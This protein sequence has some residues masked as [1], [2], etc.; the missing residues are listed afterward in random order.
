MAITRHSP[1]STR[2]TLDMLRERAVQPDAAAAPVDVEL[3]SA[4]ED[5][6]DTTSA[7]APLAEATAVPADE[8]TPH[9]P[10]HA[11]QAGQPEPQR[12]EAARGEIPRRS[13]PPPEADPRNPDP[14]ADILSMFVY[15][16]AVDGMVNTETGEIMPFRAFCRLFQEHLDENLGLCERILFRDPGLAQKYVGFVLDPGAPHKVMRHGKPYL[17]TYRPPAFAAA[18]GDIAP[19]LDLVARLFDGEEEATRFF[20]DWTA[21]QLQHPGQ[22]LPYAITLVGGPDIGKSLLGRMVAEL[23]GARNTIHLRASDL[24][25]KHND[26][27]LAARL[28][29]LD[30]MDRMSGTVARAFKRLVTSTQIWI[31]PKHAKG[32]S[33]PN[34]ISF[35]AFARRREDVTVEE[36]DKHNWV[37]VSD[38]APLDYQDA[39]ELLAWFFGEGRCYV[40]HALRSRD[41]TEFSPYAPPPAQPGHAELAA[42]SRSPTEDYL[43]EALEGGMAPLE[44]DIVILSEVTDFLRTERNMITTITEVRKALVAIGGLRLGQKRLFGPDGPKP[45]VWAIR[46]HAHWQNASED[47]IAAHHHERPDE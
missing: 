13:N 47:A 14:L 32:F 15:V 38:A 12:H 33:I 34:V 17:N 25:A 4:N 37:F 2:L 1:S 41:L 11:R 19:F 20:L 27:F 29:I 3:P 40:L 22:K 42:M 28:G 21:Y 39:G 36:A 9:E 43:R 23:V 7:A 6:H 26:C 35:L 44:K 5:A 46:R 10:A 18:E 31:E 45:N 24:V 16:A 30:D 8:S